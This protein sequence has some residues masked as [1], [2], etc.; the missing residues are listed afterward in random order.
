MNLRF[1]QGAIVVL[2]LRGFDNPTKLIG[3]VVN[4]LPDEV[5]LYPQLAIRQKGSFVNHTADDICTIHVRRELIWNLKYATIS[6]ITIPGVEFISI[7]DNET[8]NNLDYTINDFGID[9]LCKGTGTFYGN[10]KE[11]QP[12][13]FDK[14]EDDGK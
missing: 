4:V 9:G 10:I 2:E 13:F 14:L 5:E 6:C 11:S 1:N 7:P 12:T 3:K 8:H